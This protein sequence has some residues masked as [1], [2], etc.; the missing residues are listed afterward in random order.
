VPSS[1]RPSLHG[2]KHPLHPATV[3]FPI[4]FWTAAFAAD[5]VALIRGD[6]S[7]ATVAN[8]LVL[9]GIV[10]AI[11]A[12]ALGLIEYV[13]MPT[14]HPGGRTAT[15][16]AMAASGVWV[17]F[18]ARACVGHDGAGSIGRVLLSTLGLLGLAWAGWLGAE[19]VYGFS[20]GIRRQETRSTSSNGVDVATNVS[21]QIE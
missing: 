1:H 2:Q 19:L 3:H 18:V 4:A 16:H 5:F 13:Q 6:A 8:G 11:P 21:K 10:T 12:M 20:V 7:W 14:D 17:V 15:H 9:A